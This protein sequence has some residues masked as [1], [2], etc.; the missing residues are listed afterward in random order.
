MHGVCYFWE[1]GRHDEGLLMATSDEDGEKGGL[2]A[3]L[4]EAKKREG[5][6]MGGGWKVSPRETKGR[7]HVLAVRRW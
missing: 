4:H 3:R 7:G 5:A 1:P 6:R 2:M